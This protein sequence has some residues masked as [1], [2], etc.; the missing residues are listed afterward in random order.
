[1]PR[2]RSREEWLSITKTYSI[3]PKYFFRL[4]SGCPGARPKLGAKRKDD[5]V[6]R[7]I[8]TGFGKGR[9]PTGDEP[10]RAEPRLARAVVVPS[11]A[12]GRGWRPGMATGVGAPAGA[13]GLYRFA[14]AAAGRVA[15][16]AGAART[17]SLCL[18]AQNASLAGVA[19]Q[20]LVAGQPACEAPLDRLPALLARRQLG[21][22]HQGIDSALGEVDA[23][24]V[25]A[26]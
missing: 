7:T 20:L 23:D 11:H 14:S 13:D 12:P 19:H 15:A 4:D 18:N 5:Y 25:A 21:L 22:G 6:R 2:R 8:G 1:M 17:A 10:S 3:W 24:P 26:A 16:S 9:S